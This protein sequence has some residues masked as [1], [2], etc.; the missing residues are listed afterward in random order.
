M[1][2][3]EK[4]G[5]AVSGGV[6]L[7]LLALAL[8][9]LSR[10]PQFDDAQESVPV[11]IL[12]AQQFHQI[13]KGETT[14]AEVKSSQR[15][16]TIA[17]LAEL[18]PQS[19]PSEARKDVSAPPPPLKRQ[20]DP[21]Q[22]ERQETPQPPEHGAALA[23]AAPGTRSREAVAEIRADQA[24]RCAAAGTACQRSGGNGHAGTGP[25]EAG[26]AAKKDRRQN[27]SRIN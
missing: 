27:S 13:T 18:N 7:G 9:S 20:A 10:P 25:I 5:F 3:P 17:A 26:R 16:E 8:F 14:A 1:R 23:A 22:A 15:A 11:E 12:S 24:V 21:G 19:S 6:H 4:P 2:L